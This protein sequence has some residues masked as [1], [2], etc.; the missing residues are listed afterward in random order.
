MINK[1]AVS[2]L[3]SLHGAAERIC[4]PHFYIGIF[5]EKDRE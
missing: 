4:G 2:L 3:L 5:G 1:Q